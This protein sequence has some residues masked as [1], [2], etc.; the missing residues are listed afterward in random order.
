MGMGY[1]HALVDRNNNTWHDK[2]S[3]TRLVTMQ[4]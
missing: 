2:L 4:S 3:D 1:L